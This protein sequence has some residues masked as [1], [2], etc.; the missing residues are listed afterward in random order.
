M[1]ILDLQRSLRRLGRIRMGSQVATQS[2]KMRPNKLET[3]RMT[4]ISEDILHAA[5]ARYGG[6][7]Q[8]WAGAP[9]GQQWE[10]FTETDSLDAMIP[11][12]EMAFSQWHELW[13]GGG[14]MRRC[15]GNTEQ[16]SGESCMCPADPEQRRELGGKGQACKPTTRLF[17]VLPYLPDVGMWHMETH[18]FYAATELPATIEIIRLAASNGTLIPAKL[19]IEQRSVKR[20]G[21]TNNFAVPVIE[22]PTL[23]PHALMSGQTLELEASRPEL[24]SV[25]A[26]EPDPFADSPGELP[27][28]TADA[29]PAAP[30]SARS[31]P[32]PRGR[33]TDA[34]P[35]DQSTSDGSAFLRLIKQ[36]A[37]TKGLDDEQLEV[38]ALETCK[39]TFT[40]CTDP[41]S[42]N[43]L[44]KVVREHQKAQAAS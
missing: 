39:K 12:G 8:P 38:L 6:Q 17:V 40:A 24:A 3:W 19:R 30:V 37:K 10:L 14:C 7:V 42:A 28:C 9:S 32:K 11:P 2:G 43:E 21:T 33:A 1:P 23:T 5:A 31:A 35:P 26:A 41:K 27:P 18:G 20:D 29:E 36:A 16:L 44:L 25:P 13:S 15:D 4:S 34:V 22:L